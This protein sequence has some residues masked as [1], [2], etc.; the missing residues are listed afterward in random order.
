ME[1]IRSRVLRGIALNRTPG[2]H[3]SG[4]FLAIE[5]AEVG[6]RT[7]VVMEAGPHATGAD[8]Q[9]HIGPVLMVADIA[10]AASIR[11]RLSPATRLATVSMHVQ[12]NGRPMRGTIEARSQFCGF[13]EGAA[14]TLGLSRV[15]ILAGGEEAG[16]GHGTF[17]ALD[18][19]PG[20]TMHPVQTTRVREVDLPAEE[21][22]DESERGILKRA[23]A[24]LAGGD[25]SFIS[26]FLGISP[27]KTDGGASCRMENGAHV[28]NRVGHAQGGIL[29]GLAA[30]TAG[31]ALGAQ[32]PL[33]SI[34]A[35]FTS[36]GEGDVLEASAAV[37][38]RG[39]WTAVVRVEV[40]APQGRRVLE[41]T[42]THARRTE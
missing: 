12:M 15:A 22:L 1:D 31:A 6:E 41:A 30:A 20:V 18:P 13:A 32:W 16:F 7:R 27:R 28:G 2:F 39:R 35:S 14:S 23:E 11:A 29:M 24:A 9:V 34:A 42:T 4:N 26:R 10:L 3:F 33:A 8:E 5:L 19:P 36:P 37:V 40:T 38:H 17:M 21:S 25:G